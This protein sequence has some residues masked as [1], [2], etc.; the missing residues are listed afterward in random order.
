MLVLPA[1]LLGA[2]LPDIIDK[3]LCLLIGSPSRWVAHSFLVILPLTALAV[4]FLR[5]RSRVFISLQLG[6]LMHLIED[7]AEYDLLLWPFKYSESGSGQF[8][9][10]TTLYNYYVLHVLP[11]SLFLE[12]L[13]T[14][15]CIYLIGYES[16]F[17]YPRNK[18]YA[19]SEVTEET[20]EMA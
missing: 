7:I 12:V 10:F 17:A 11:I 14:L 3:S 4:L 18:G 16:F 19:K 5:D 8:S 2:F 20:T 6:I 15:I 9:F 1:F 13:C